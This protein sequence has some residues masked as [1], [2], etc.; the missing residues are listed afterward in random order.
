MSQAMPYSGFK[1]VD[2]N[3]FTLRNYSE[4][5]NNK[6]SKGYILEV[7]LDYPKKLHELHNEYPYCLNKFLWKIKC[8]LTFQKESL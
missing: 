6:S 3:E 2:S 1:W 4:L 7:H 5:S 8:Y